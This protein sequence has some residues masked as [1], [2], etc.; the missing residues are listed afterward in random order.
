MRIGLPR[1]LTY[2]EYAPLWKSFFQALGAEVVVS[3]PTTR[4]TLDIATSHATADLCLPVKLY[5]GHLLALAEEVDL[6]FVPS[7]RRPM[8]SATHCAKIVG[9]PD[10]ARSVV[11]DG[12]E[13][14]S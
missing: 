11:R 4:A 8:R 1:A 9:L 12:M 13:T 5:A 3:R 2:Y 14:P 10:L 6:L 7:L